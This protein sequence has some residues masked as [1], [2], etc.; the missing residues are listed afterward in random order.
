M[1]GGDRG[2]RKEFEREVPGRDGIERIGHGAVE[3]QGCRGGVPVDGEGGAG[4][5]GGAEGAFV[6][7]LPGI[8]EAGAV[9]GEHLHIS[10]HVVAPGDGLGRLEVREAGHDPVGPGLGLHQAGAH[11]G[12]ERRIDLVDP[13]AGP[14]AEVGGD[15][16]VSGPGGVKAPGGFAD[17][18][19]QPCFDVHVDVFEG[20][21]ESE[22]AALDL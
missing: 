3:A 10:Q 11:E 4:E 6:Q 22:F 19:L 1:H 14:E 5:G 20:G 15:L 7:A 8:G 12:G 18:L 9:A 2:G 16:V 17:Q 21:G 13:V